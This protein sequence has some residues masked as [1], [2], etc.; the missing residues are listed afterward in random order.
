VTLRDLRVILNLALGAGV[1]REYGR[2][3][4][5]RGKRD[6]WREANEMVT[7]FRRDYDVMPKNATRSERRL[8][9]RR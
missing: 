4:Y 6:A 3:E 9:S 7:R 1:I 8:W 5:A 2:S